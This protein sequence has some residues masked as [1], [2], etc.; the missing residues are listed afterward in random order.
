MRKCLKAL[1][2]VFCQISS[3]W[4]PT[5]TLCW[6]LRLFSEARHLLSRQ[7][8]AGMREGFK[9][10]TNLWYELCI[11]SWVQ[12]MET[13]IFQRRGYSPVAS[14]DYLMNLFPRRSYALLP[15]NQYLLVPCCTYVCESTYIHIYIYIYIYIICVWVHVF[16]KVTQT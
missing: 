1:K 4:S 15:L 7:K 11:S 10:S 9:A 6:A 3:Y 12:Q 2:V 5:K 13:F 8:P 14:L 16:T